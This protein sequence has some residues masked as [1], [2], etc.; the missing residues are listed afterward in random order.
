VL[1]MHPFLALARCH[2]SASFS[3]SCSLLCAHSRLAFWMVCQRCRKAFCR[4]RT[5]VMRALVWAAEHSSF[6]QFAPLGSGIHFY[7]SVDL[8][9]L[10]IMVSNIYRAAWA[11]ITGALIR[12]SW[13]SSAVLWSRVYGR[14][15][16]NDIA[17]SRTHASLCLGSTL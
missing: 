6:H 15:C 17:N 3:A 7:F 13:T 12:L 9:A 11:V 2:M 8:Q 10:S 1:V 16:G 4:S 5:F 14:H